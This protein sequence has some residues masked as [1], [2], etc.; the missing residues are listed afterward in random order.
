[1][2]QGLTRLGSVNWATPGKSDTRL[3]CKTLPDRT[4]RSSRTSRPGRV[5][6]RTERRCFRLNMDCLR[7]RGR[8]Q[9]EKT[10]GCGPIIAA[11]QS[12]DDP[13]DCC[14]LTRYPK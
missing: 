10:I 5:E 14:A 6:E 9:G 8:K 7:S 13:T 2:P 11:D 1:M 12:E 4:Q 3:V